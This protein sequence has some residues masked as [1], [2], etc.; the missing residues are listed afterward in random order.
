MQ[1]APTEKGQ[2]KRETSKAFLLSSS[3]S[4]IDGGRDPSLDHPQRSCG[5][6]LLSPVGLRSWHKGRKI[7]L[8]GG[9]SDK[10]EMGPWRATLQDLRM[11][12]L[13]V[14]AVYTSATS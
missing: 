13:L 1:K 10:R 9:T 14:R 2:V 4:P 12:K 5:S 3:S 11:S 8:H 7:S 6:L